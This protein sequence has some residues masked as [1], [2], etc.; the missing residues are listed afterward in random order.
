MKEEMTIR[1]LT[2]ILAD[3]ARELSSV[4]TGYDKQDGHTLS[5]LNNVISAIDELAYEVESDFAN[6]TQSSDAIGAYNKMLAGL[7]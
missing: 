6:Y 5:C 3:C 2:A 4:Y 7:K 1:T